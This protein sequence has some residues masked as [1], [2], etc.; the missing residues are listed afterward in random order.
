[1]HA[2]TIHSEAFTA[3]WL[4]ASTVTTLPKPSIMLSIGSCTYMGTNIICV[5]CHRIPSSDLK[6]LHLQIRK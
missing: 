1:M 5:H 2:Q 3:V 6:L 4:R